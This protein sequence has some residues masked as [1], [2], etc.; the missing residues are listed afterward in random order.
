M[1]ATPHRELIALQDVGTGFPNP[2]LCLD[3]VGL[4]HV[5]S[6]ESHTLEKKLDF[7]ISLI[8]KIEN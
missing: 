2:G 4:T 8:I 1:A 3:R 6:P 7:G 5:E